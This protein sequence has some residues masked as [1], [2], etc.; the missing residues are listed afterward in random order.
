MPQVWG[1]QRCLG[2][3][4]RARRGSDRQRGGQ[5]R[6]RCHPHRARRRPL[7]AQGPWLDA[8]PRRGAR[9][10]RPQARHGHGATSRARDGTTHRRAHDAT[11]RLYAHDA[12]NGER[13]RPPPPRHPRRPVRA[14]LRRARGGGARSPH[15]AR[16]ADPARLRIRPATACTGA[17][18]ELGE[19]D[20]EQGKT[21]ERAKPYKSLDHDTNPAP[22]RIDPRA[23]LRVRSL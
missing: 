14:P 4:T 21:R 9:G 11:T 3:P 12:R 16:R 5:R 2:G 8:S 15:A 6:S 20:D 17:A 1:S 18:R 19:N 22:I 10:G 13:A 23:P 7:H